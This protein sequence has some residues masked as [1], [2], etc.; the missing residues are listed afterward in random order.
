MGCM[1]VTFHS[2]PLGI[3]CTR[4]SSLSASARSTQYVQHL[5]EVFVVA[6]YE[7]MIS[8]GNP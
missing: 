7:V 5:Y 1:G 3:V 2:L 6:L 8:E 4:E